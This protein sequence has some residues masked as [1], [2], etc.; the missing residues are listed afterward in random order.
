[1]GATKQ[2]PRIFWVATGPLSCLPIHASSQ[3]AGQ[4]AR[5]LSDY[6]V[7]SYAPSLSSLL[8]KQV[9]ETPS[10]IL[11][12]IQSNTPGLTRLPQAAA[13]LHQLS[14]AAQDGNI[15]L[16]TLADGNALRD[17]VKTQLAVSK[18]NIVHFAC[19]GHHDAQNP[20][21]SSLHL[22][23]GS[24]QLGEIMDIGSQPRILPVSGYNP[25]TPSIERSDRLV[26]LNACQTA[27]GDPKLPDQVL[28][29]A[30]VFLFGG[31]FRGAI[32][33]MWAINDEDGARVAGSFYRKLFPAA[34]DQGLDP[35]AVH[36]RQKSLNLDEAARALRDA[37]A[38]LKASGAS[39]ARCAPFVHVGI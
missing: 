1:M 12:V 11:A 8:V 9:K 30:G 14:A 34:T 32:A 25:G 23:D 10:N 33:T 22:H 2:S 29:L 27:R 36:N 3:G 6:A 16:T 38:E 19:H 4:H 20:L 39:L 13:E 31:G 28:N 37:V 21:Q 5:W 17:T 26:F 15:S 7:S 18:Y 35:D 24:L